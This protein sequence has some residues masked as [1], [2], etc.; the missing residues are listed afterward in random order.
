M[1]NYEAPADARLTLSSAQGDVTVDLYSDEGLALVS[2]LWTKLAAQHRLMYELSWLGRP[3]IQLPTDIVVMQELIWRLRPDVIVETGVAHGGSLILSASILELLG[4]DGF[5]VGV[6]IDIRA[7]NRAAIEAHPL[8]R[9]IRLIEGSSTAPETVAAV[10]AACG[11]A[12]RVLVILDSNHTEAHVRAEIDLYHALVTPGS[13]LVVHDGA[14]AWVSDIP[15]GKPEW[16]DDHPL[17]AIHAF[18][19]QR[20]DFE[21]DAQ[22]NRLLITSS[23]DGF[24]RRIA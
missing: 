16:R 23:P 12:A 22:M 20:T 15:R 5:V 17:T 19:A 8:A 11:D 13:Y 7:H 24:L 9:R 6:D 2:N 18:L 3:I 10:R 14:Q 4:G 21:I 1:R